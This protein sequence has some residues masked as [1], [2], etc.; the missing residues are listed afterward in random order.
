[1]KNIGVMVGRFSPLHLG[2]QRTID[3]MVADKGIENC[4]VLIGSSVSPLSWRVLFPY[5]DRARW[6]R[7]IYGK[8]LKIVG[9][10][11][12]LS[13]DVHWLSMLDDYIN[14]VFPGEKEVTFY[15]GSQEDIEFFYTHGK[16][17][18]Y[19]CDRTEYPISAT[20]VRQM[21]LNGDPITDVVDPSIG[22][23]VIEVFHKRLKQLDEL[24]G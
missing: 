24:R 8:N 7:R 17:K 15:G 5:E 13:S 10:P 20:K 9:M 6:L 11:D 23:E 21:L 3:K 12:V 14:A 19:I 16:R 18:V 2:H 4:L 1:M 22:K